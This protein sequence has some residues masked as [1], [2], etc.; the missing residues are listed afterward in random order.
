M[1]GARGG[2]QGSGRRFD[3]GLRPFLELTRAFLAPSAAADG[4]AG[5]ALASLAL[6]LAPRPAAAAAAALSSALLY[7]AGA[8]ANDFFDVAKDRV[9]APGRPLPSGRISPRAAAIAAGA[10][11]ASGAA[12]A[13]AL[14][15]AGQ[16]GAIIA[17]A[18][19]YDAGGKRVPVAGSLLLGACRAAN[20]LLGAAA[21]AGGPAAL[22]D[23]GVLGAAAAIGLYT[24]GITAASRA[25]DSGRRGWFLLASGLVLAV[26]LAV[27]LARPADPGVWI[28]AAAV[29]LAA[30]GPLRADL[31][32]DAVPRAAAR[33]VARALGA[34]YLLDAALVLALGPPGSRRWPWIAPL[35]ALWILAAALRRARAA[36]GLS[37][38]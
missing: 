30:G 2:A 3:G 32:R 4:F 9:S 29:A 6:G 7:A 16:A 37:E 26:P 14:G 34:I 5:F 28:H 31:R 15:A 21:A 22:G 27:A 18:L 11:A 13:W 33:F 25:E 17:A 10:L 20:L 1:R 19:L 8:A 38:S 23:R 12:I 24:C 36:R 35:Y